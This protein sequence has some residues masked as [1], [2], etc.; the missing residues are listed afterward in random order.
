MADQPA[1]VVKAEHARNRLNAAPASV[2]LRL[3][4]AP[5][6]Q[7]CPEQLPALIINMGQGRVTVAGVVDR[8][9][10]GEEALVFVAPDES[11]DSGAAAR[12][13]AGYEHHPFIAQREEVHAFEIVAVARAVADEERMQV[14]PV[15]QIVRA[16]EQRRPANAI[17]VAADRHIPA[18]ISAPDVRIAEIARLEAMRRD[19]GQHGV[20]AVLSPA[21]QVFIAKS[22][23]LT[24]ASN[25]R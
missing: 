3:A 15:A 12:V 11:Q 22:Q 13:H 23:A 5:L 4:T 25:R 9:A 8:L 2:E 16:I 21:R 17:D 1:L 7:P 19:I 14:L 6:P 10:F 20:A 24:C 18:V